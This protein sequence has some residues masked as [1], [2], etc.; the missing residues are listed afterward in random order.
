[1]VD[2]WSRFTSLCPNWIAELSPNTHTSHQAACKLLF[3]S[4]ES[5]FVFILDTFSGYNEVRQIPFIKYKTNYF[6]FSEHLSITV[7]IIC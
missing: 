7:P 4:H 5:V 2:G 6:N 3:I 1:M